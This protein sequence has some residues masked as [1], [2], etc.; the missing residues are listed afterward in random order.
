MEHII[1]GEMVSFKCGISWN[2]SSVVKWLASSEVDCG[3]Y[4]RW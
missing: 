2:I 1:G 3:T 4:H